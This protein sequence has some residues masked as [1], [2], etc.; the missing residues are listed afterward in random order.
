[1]AGKLDP[2]AGL[3]IDDCSFRSICGTLYI[4]EY[5]LKELNH[6]TVYA[7]YLRSSSPFARDLLGHI[8]QQTNHEDLDRTVQSHELWFIKSSF[9]EYKTALLAELGSLNSYFITQK[10][11]HDT[12]SLLMYGESL[13]PSDI[14]TKVPEAKFDCC[15]AAKCLAFEVPTACAFHVF[16]AVESVLRRYY[17][18]ATEGKAAPKS[19]NLG[20][21]LA[22]MKQKNFGNPKVLAALKQLID[23]HRNPL[24][25]PEAVITVDE[26]LAIIGISSSLMTA[27]LAEL[28][29]AQL[30]TTMVPTP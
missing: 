17:A 23:L 25:H 16:R 1:M 14:A 13:F 8:Q 24:I 4:A 22:A 3:P 29:S 9:D 21:Y 7:P 30:T 11:S 28:P 12:Y 26:A 2:L 27:M 19:R 10:G 20:V 5:A 6:S 15:E 18:S